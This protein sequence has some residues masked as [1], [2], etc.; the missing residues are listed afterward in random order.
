MK[1]TYKIYNVHDGTS[2][3]K[4]SIQYDENMQIQEY[5]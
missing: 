4:I 3:S 2:I 5:G 1:V